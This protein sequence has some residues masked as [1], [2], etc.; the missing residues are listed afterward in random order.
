MSPYAIGLSTIETD[1]EDDSSGPEKARRNSKTTGISEQFAQSYSVMALC[2]DNSAPYT[3]CAT[4]LPC[5][6]KLYTIAQL[7]RGFTPIRPIVNK[8]KLPRMID[9]YPV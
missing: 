9:I 7:P 1:K 5:R 3:M 4:E 6:F 2:Y 8:P